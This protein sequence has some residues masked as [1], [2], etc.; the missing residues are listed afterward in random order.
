[1]NIDFNRIGIGLSAAEREVSICAADDEEVIHVH[2]DSR[3]FARRLSEIATAW[4]ATPRPMG[5]GFEVDLP[6]IALKLVGP[7]RQSRLSEA[8]R[9]ERR[10]RIAKARNSRRVHVRVQ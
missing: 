2:C 8:E 1:M 5:A 10:H 4:G 3:R 7:R 6:L 9:V